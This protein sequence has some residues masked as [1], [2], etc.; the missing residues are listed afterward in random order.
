VRWLKLMR[1]KSINYTLYSSSMVL[2]AARFSV[3]RHIVA[4]GEADG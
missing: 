4:G 3:L 2:Y 1:R